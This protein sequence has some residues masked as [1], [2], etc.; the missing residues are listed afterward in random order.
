MH[1]PDFLKLMRR[2][3]A[4]LAIGASSL[5][6]MVGSSGVEIARG[7]CES[8]PLDPVSNPEGFSDQLDILTADLAR[9][10]PRRKLQGGELWGPARKQ[11][12]I[13]LS[14]AVYNHYLRDAYRL[15][16][17][18]SM[19]EV[20]VDSFVAAG[21]VDHVRKLKLEYRFS[22]WAGVVHLTLTNPL[23]FIDKCIDAI[24]PVLIDTSGTGVSERMHG[25]GASDTRAV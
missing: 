4:A 23:I 6:N 7:F 21:I 19:L 5:R 18:E 11:L 20:P 13:F 12:N 3:V 25:N 10:L 24:R 14:D 8:I 9:K 2:R 17:V 1:E 16:R 22:K 15:E